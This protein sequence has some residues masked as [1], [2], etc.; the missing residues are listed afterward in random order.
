MVGSIA[1]TLLGKGNI[2]VDR[3]DDTRPN[4][5]RHGTGKTTAIIFG[6]ADTVRTTELRSEWGISHK[7][8]ELLFKMCG[9][10][11]HM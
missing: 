6:A 8:V 7:M 1:T 5:S 10:A 11:V 9:T 4:G 3:S 2:V